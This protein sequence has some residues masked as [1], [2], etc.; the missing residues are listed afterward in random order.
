MTTSTISPQ[1]EK[2]SGECGVGADI[3]ALRKS[4]GI[5]L[6]DMATMLGRSIG[7]LSQVE[8]QQTQPAISDLRE[9]AQMFEIPIS[10]FFRNEIADEDERGLIVR[11]KTRA[12]F[13]SRRDGL[14]EELLSP[15]LSGDFE[16]I[17]SEFAPHSKSNL[18]KA[19]PTHEGG[20]LIAGEITL[21]IKGKQFELYTGDSFQFQN[22][23]Y[24]WENRSNETAILIWIISPPIY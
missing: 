4:R 23:E 7:W 19:R 16:M 18:I 12:R 10:F 24:Q 14:I 13:G 15:S 5:T 22:E 17:R 1:L 21:W 9:I 20:Y 11:S 2:T 6:A 3:R 8:R